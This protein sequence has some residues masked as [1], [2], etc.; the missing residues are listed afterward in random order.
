[1]S[2]S[3]QEAGRSVA[4]ALG[5][6]GA[7]VDA[8]ASWFGHMWPDDNAALAFNAWVAAGKAVCGEDEH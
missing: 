1:M 6:E 2:T 8:F 5:A 7:Q 4:V 3:K